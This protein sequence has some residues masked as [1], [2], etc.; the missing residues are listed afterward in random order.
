MTVF[1][2][3]KYLKE[4]MV[5]F[6][7]TFTKYD[8]RKQSGTERIPSGFEQKVKALNHQLEEKTKQFEILKNSAKETAEGLNKTT[9][10]V[11]D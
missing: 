9:K 5:R 10:N 6:K 11:L 8:K 4:K 3:K 1:E 7:G 2:L